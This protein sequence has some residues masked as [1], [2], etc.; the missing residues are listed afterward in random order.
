MGAGG[1]ITSRPPLHQR[2]AAVVLAAGLS[3]RM[4]ANK[5]LADLHGQPLLSVTIASA[6]AAGVDEVIIVTGHQASAVRAAVSNSSP[7]F[8]HNADFAQG[9]VTSIKAGILAVQNFDAA[10]IML[11][12]M[13]LVRPDDLK[14]MMAAFNVEE[15]RTIIAPVQG[16]KLGNPV[17]WG[18]EHFPSLQAL[19]GD[20]GGR[21]LLEAHRTDIVEI[22]IAHDG[23]LLDADSPE[24]LDVIRRSK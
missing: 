20:R 18:K 9:I 10:F 1:L 22:A 21:S 13:P 16:R 23:I 8:V 11:G 5:L 7:R 24:A 6:V 3:T 12:D 2:I 15:G 4:G 19:Q 17:L 14:R